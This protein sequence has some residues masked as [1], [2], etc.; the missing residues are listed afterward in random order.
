MS[1]IHLLLDNGEQ[2]TFP[3]AEVKELLERKSIAVHTPFWTDGMFEWRP[4]SELDSPSVVPR[5]RTDKPITNVP[6]PGAVVRTPASNE[7]KPSERN[8]YLR[9]NPIPLTIALQILSLISLGAMGYFMNHSLGLIYV[10]DVS[11]GESSSP[12][13]SCLAQENNLIFYFFVLLGLHI[14]VETVFFYWLFDANKNSR[15]M[16]TNIR[17][18]P[19]WSVGCF[20]VPFVNCYMPYQVMQEIWKVSENPRSWNGR[21]DSIFVGLW[22]LTR[23]SIVLLL[24]GF[25]QPT[26]G[27]DDPAAQALRTVAYLTAVL[28]IL[29]AIEFT[30]LLL[31][32]TVTWRQLRWAKE[33]S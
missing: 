18:T 3:K 4:L 21:S 8:F 28:A 6:I 32:S 33:A 14:V 13:A 30:T 24:L 26:S 5:K 22:F 25:L 27:D 2:M 7:W 16:A 1:T 12:G 17:Y 29:V 20:F 9:V 11:F 19:G 23:V 31:V 15:A 10:R